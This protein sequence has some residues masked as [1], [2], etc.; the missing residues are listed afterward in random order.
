MTSCC[1]V[2]KDNMVET[3]FLQSRQ[4]RY[5]K[6]AM[7]GNCSLMFLTWCQCIMLRQM[8]QIYTVL[9]MFSL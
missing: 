3:T 5:C 8:V 6:G 9:Q 4:V 2:N 1:N 7:F